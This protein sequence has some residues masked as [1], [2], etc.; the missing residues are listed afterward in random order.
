MTIP[1]DWQ[2]L[3]GALLGIIIVIGIICWLTPWRKGQG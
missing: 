1:T 2:F 3:V